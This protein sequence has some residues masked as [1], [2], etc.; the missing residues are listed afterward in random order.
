MGVQL[1]LQRHRQIG[2]ISPHPFY[3]GQEV[4]VDDPDGGDGYAVII[5]NFVKMRFMQGNFP[6]MVCLL[7]YDELGRVFL[8]ASMNLMRPWEKE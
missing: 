4:L 8:D 5:S 2:P 6:G 1:K 7:A 3:M